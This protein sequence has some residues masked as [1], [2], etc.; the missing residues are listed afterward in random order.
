MNRRPLL[1]APAVIAG[2]T[3]APLQALDKKDKPK[4]YKLAFIVDVPDDIAE[5]FQ[6]SGNNRSF[7]ELAKFC[8]KVSGVV[9]EPNKDRVSLFGRRISRI[10]L[11]RDD[12]IDVGA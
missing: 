7:D 6:V 12:T 10:T 1:S 4:M 3:V 2:A 9:Y 11:T 5:N 8:D